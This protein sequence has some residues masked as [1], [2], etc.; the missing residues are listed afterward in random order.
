MATEPIKKNAPPTARR[1]HI[2][3]GLLLLLAIVVVIVLVC[4][5]VGQERFFYFY[6]AAGYQG[7]TADLAYTFTTN[8]PLALKFIRDSINLEYNYL[9]AL[10]LI[11][12][13]IF[14]GDHRLV[15]ELTAALIYQLPYALVLGAI[16]SRLIAAS[17]EF[18]DSSNPLASVNHQSDKLRQVDRR[19]RLAFWITVFVTLANPTAWGPL[20]RGLPDVGSALLI[21][22]AVWVYLLDPTLKRPWQIVT[23]GGLLALAM[24]FRRHFAYAVGAFYI[25]GSLQYTIQFLLQVRK[26]GRPAWTAFWHKGLRL[27]LAAVVTLLVTVLLALPFLTRIFTVNYTALY[28]SYLLPWK[29]LLLFYADQYRTLVLILVVLGF[30]LGLRLRL[31]DKAGTLFILLFT[32]IVLVVWNTFAGQRGMQYSLHFTYLIILGL[33]VLLLAILVSTNPRYR[34]WLAIPLAA[35]LVING[36]FGMLWQPP[37]PFGR[38]LSYGYRPMVRSDYA[39]VAR[40]VAYLR[41]VVPPGAPIYVVD[42]SYAMNAD[43]IAKAEQNLYGRPDAHFI[44]L[45]SPIIDSRDNYPL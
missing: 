44:V 25:A 39:E 13:L 14:F 4:V 22:L 3:D 27:C 41:E 20:L 43:M 21:A 42:S 36:L 17:S 1:L 15:Y 37:A 8:T 31:L 34:L 38:L 32:G 40:L 11:P 2:L 16:A 9:F 45:V 24:I 28:A 12:F 6:D 26:T 30:V 29:D 35:F 23:T 5:Y 18:P 10:P 7:I 33:S 19:R